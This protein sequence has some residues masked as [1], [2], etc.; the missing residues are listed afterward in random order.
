M[1]IEYLREF[2]VLANT[3]NLTLTSKQLNMTQ[4]AL[5]NHVK[6]LE[7]EIGVTLFDRGDAMTGKTPKMTRAGRSFLLDAERILDSY[8]EAI[9]KA[10]Q[11]QEQERDRIVFRLPRSEMSAEPLTLIND[12]SAQ[13]PNIRIEI[14]SWA[15]A[16]I[17]DDILSGEVD[18]GNFGSFFHDSACSREL[19]VDLLPYGTV[20]LY[21]LVS[22]D[23]ELLVN[24]SLSIDNLADANVLVPAN[25][26]ATQSTYVSKNIIDHYNIKARIKSVY[27]DSVE[28]FVF[29][30]L[31]GRDVI[32]LDSQWVEFL[33]LRSRRDGMIAKFQPGIELSLCLAFKHDSGNNSLELLKRFTAESAGRH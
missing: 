32:L 33:P 31:S 8:D 22:N 21:G 19:A 12:F 18:C 9:Q 29:T 27:C 10:K 15:P 14:R 3:L 5:S 11:E 13:Y 20:E 30:P 28:E 23:S 1:H 7:H 16:D 26:K 17:V 6:A 2:I 4:P 24:G 25:Q